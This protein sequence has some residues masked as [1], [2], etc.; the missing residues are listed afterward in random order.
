MAQ[1]QS[2][3]NHVRVHGGVY[4]GSDE[5]KVK[6]FPSAIKLPSTKGTVPGKKGGTAVGKGT[7]AMPSQ[8]ALNAAAKKGGEKAMKPGTHGGAGRSAG[9]P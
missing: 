8:G 1:I 5:G 3:S 2:V 7:G 6:G 4:K 9:T